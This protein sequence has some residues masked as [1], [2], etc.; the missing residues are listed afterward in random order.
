MSQLLPVGGYLLLFLIMALLWLFVFFRGA[1]P[2]KISK[3]IGPVGMGAA[4]FSVYLP[5]STRAQSWIAGIFQESTVAVWIVVI[6]MVLLSAFIL[7]SFKAL[8]I[9]LNRLLLKEEISWL[10]SGLA[11]GLGFALWESWRLVAIPFGRLGMWF[12]LSVLERLSG[13]G[14]HLGLT[15]IAAYGFYTNRIWQTFIVTVLSHSVANYIVL[16]HDV[17]V[18]RLWPTQIL[19]LVLAIAAQAIAA[20]LF[21]KVKKEAI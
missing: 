6:P 4:A 5:L 9:W 17:R 3:Y 14:I 21:H 11:V 1:F 18:L 7:V 8:G 2:G 13:I 12:P 19:L 16:L 10:T 20:R 15:F